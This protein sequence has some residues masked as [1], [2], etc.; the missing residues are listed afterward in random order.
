M[1]YLFVY[2]IFRYMR[3]AGFEPATY[4]LKVRYSTSWV[5]GASYWQ[6][7]LFTCNHCNNSVY[8][9]VC[10]EVNTLNEMGCEPIVSSSSVKKITLIVDFSKSLPWIFIVAFHHNINDKLFGLFNFRFTICFLLLINSKPWRK[11]TL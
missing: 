11:G 5:I 7:L 2:Y 6:D 3:R 9:F 4:G 1:H 8:T 10:R